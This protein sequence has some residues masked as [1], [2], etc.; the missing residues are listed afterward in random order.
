MGRHWVAARD[1]A[2]GEV[3][4]EERPLVAGPKA[5]SPPVCLVCYATPPAGRGRCADC[6]WPVCG[7]TTCRT[8]PAHRAECSLIAGHYIGSDDESD[9]RT[10]TY[11]FVLPLRCLLLADHRDR[12]AFRSLQSH[13]DARLD[14]PLYR[15]Y[16]VNVAS[17]VLD[18]L[19]L[20]SAGHDERSVLEAAAVL[21]TNAFEVRRDG[22]K[23]RA[24][25]AAA[26]MMAHSCT[27]NTKHVFF[28]DENAIRVVAAVPIGRGQPITATY[29]QTLWCTR[30][31]RRHLWAAKCFRCE[32]RRC[33]DPTELATNIGSDACQACT[34]GRLSPGHP[35]C[36]RC[37]HRQSDADRSSLERCV[38]DAERRVRAIGK[39]DCSGFELFLEQVR[40]NAVPPLHADHYVAVGVK[41]AL[42]QLY[43]DRI[44]GATRFYPPPLYCDEH[45]TFSDTYAF[46]YIKPLLSPVQTIRPKA[47]VTISGVDLCSDLIAPAYCPNSFRICCELAFGTLRLNTSH[48]HKI[49]FIF[50]KI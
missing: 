21:D 7:T 36:D 31:R 10:A 19:G 5:A 3:L 40:A 12:V 25:Y 11:S 48:A 33:N 27:A 15:V 41:Y 47:N 20:R 44:S 35:E 18:R 32:C 4:L 39:T 46:Y 49:Y 24:L 14:T 50:S 23:F 9:R 22:R 45:V 28:G 16:A 26:S 2:A 13:L 43:S 34:A 38:D 37:G 42:V 17:F 30:D 29:T 8:S 1:V 6:G